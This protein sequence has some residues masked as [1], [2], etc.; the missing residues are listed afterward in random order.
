MQ[1]GP[2]EGGGGGGGDRGGFRRGGGEDNTQAAW[3][4]CTI[5]DY[6]LHDTSLAGIFI[7]QS[8][9]LPLYL[10]FLSGLREGLL[11]QSG[12]TSKCSRARPEKTTTGEEA[13]AGL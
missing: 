4:L 11:T 13:P 3:S 12:A 7:H 10:V 5:S 6:H 9:P 8:F 1:D 2:R